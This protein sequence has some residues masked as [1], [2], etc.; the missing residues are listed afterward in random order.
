MPR[1]SAP[2]SIDAG[3]RGCVSFLCV[4]S[5]NNGASGRARLSPIGTAFAVSVKE[6]SDAEFDYFITSKHIVQGAQQGTLVI[7][8]PLID[9]S[10]ADLRTDPEKDWI[11]HSDPKADVAVCPVSGIPEDTA[12]L[13]VPVD[14]LVT[15]EMLT[16]EGVGTGNGLFSVGLFEPRA[17]DSRVEPIVSFGSIYLMPQL[18]GTRL[19]GPDSHP[20]EIDAYLTEWPTWGGTSGSPVFLCSPVDG[21]TEGRPARSPARLL[22][23]L[24]SHINLDP[25]TEMDSG[26]VTSGMVGID[27]GLG[28]VVPA[29]RITELLSMG[30]AAQHRQEAIEAH[31]LGELQREREDAIDQLA[32]VEARS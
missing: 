17:D 23:L 7:R 25:E 19:V 31:L 24:Q 5:R 26:A 29:Q 1:G 11:S 4:E 30:Q 12:V 18:V 10:V 15:D 2:L 3:A 28:A 9:G 32:H 6:R 13:P 8:V 16:S 21:E 22:G 20:L 27:F 14:L